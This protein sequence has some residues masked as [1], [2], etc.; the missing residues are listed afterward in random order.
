MGVQA[1]IGTSLFIPDVVIHSTVTECLLCAWLCPSVAKAEKDP[2]PHEPCILVEDTD[3][4]LKYMKSD[5]S[6]RYEAEQSRKEEGS[7]R[8]VLGSVAVGRGLWG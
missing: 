3:Q 4:R 7:R 1:F 8:A 2:C 5:R 6:E